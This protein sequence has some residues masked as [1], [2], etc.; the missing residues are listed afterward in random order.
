MWGC[1]LV[2]VLL[3]NVHSVSLRSTSFLSFVRFHEAMIGAFALL[4]LGD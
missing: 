3:S 4:A 2:P 1:M